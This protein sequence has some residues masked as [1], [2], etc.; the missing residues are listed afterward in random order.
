MNLSIYGST[1]VTLRWTTE[2]LNASL[3]DFIT[4]KLCSDLQEPKH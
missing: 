3:L 1:L 4:E 2:L